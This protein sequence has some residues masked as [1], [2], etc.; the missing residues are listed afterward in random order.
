MEDATNLMIMVTMMIVKIMMIV[1]IV[2]PSPRIQDSCTK[3]LSVSGPL[4]L[5]V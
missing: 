2:N 1:M 5:N 3:S 4:D